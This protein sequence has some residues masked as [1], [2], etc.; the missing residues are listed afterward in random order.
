[1]SGAQGFPSPT[2]PI[3]DP[4]TG[5]LTPIWLRFL[6]AIFQRTGGASGSSA[7]S[8][9]TVTPTASPFAYA[10]PSSGSLLISG[11]GVSNLQFSRDGT[12]W[13]STGSFYGSFEMSQNDLVEIAY[14]GSPPTVIFVPH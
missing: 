10:A 5:T 13:F 8:P 14:P 11:G 9:L 2:V 1:V 6:L 4:A 7:G 12:H 3:V